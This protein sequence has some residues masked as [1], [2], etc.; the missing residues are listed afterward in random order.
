MT[1]HALPRFP[2]AAAVP[3]LLAVAVLLA[4]L[5]PAAGMADV[6]MHAPKHPATGIPMRMYRMCASFHNE[7]CAPQSGGPCLDRADCV[8]EVCDA[9]DLPGSCANDYSLDFCDDVACPFVERQLRHPVTRLAA[10]VWPY[11]RD[12]A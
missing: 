3:L 8:A 10:R 4:A 6:D 2:A 1:R 9:P 12:A 7:V 5:P 11:R